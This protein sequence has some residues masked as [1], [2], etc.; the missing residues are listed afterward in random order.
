MWRQGGWVHLRAI[1]VYN[2]SNGSRTDLGRPPKPPEERLVTLSVRI[3]RTSLDLIEK[4]VAGELE[5]LKKRRLPTRGVHKSGAFRTIWELGETEYFLQR[6]T[7][8]V[9]RKTN[10]YTVAQAAEQLGWDPQT[11]RRLLIERGVEAGE[12]APSGP[13]KDQP[14]P[15]PPLDPRFLV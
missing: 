3:P 7:L 6:A 13:G 4:V 15:S 8:W 10:R 11:L 12:P 5:F 9:T 14:P 2:N 1:L